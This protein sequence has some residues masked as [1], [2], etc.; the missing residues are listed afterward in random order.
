[1][2]RVHHLDGALFGVSDWSGRDTVGCMVQTEEEHT[3][4]SHHYPSWVKFTKAI[5]SGV[6]YLIGP[7]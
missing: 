5:A 3:A 6:T 7:V 4:I 2:K 1:M